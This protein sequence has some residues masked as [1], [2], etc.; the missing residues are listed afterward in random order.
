MRIFQTVPERY[1]KDLTC[2]K[3]NKDGVQM[4]FRIAALHGFIVTK[5]LLLG[6]PRRLILTQISPVIAI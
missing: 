4:P 2:E 3:A 1:R 6:T 5:T